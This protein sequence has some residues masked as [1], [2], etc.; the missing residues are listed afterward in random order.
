MSLI[1]RRPQRSP[2]RLP[3]QSPL[4]RRL[5]SP[6]PV[7]M[8]PQLQTPAR[9]TVIPTVRLAMVVAAR[10]LCR[11]VQ[12]L[13]HRALTASASSVLAVGQGLLTVVSSLEIIP[14][15]STHH[16]LVKTTQASLK[17]ALVPVLAVFLAPRRQ[18]YLLQRFC[19]LLPPRNVSDSH[20]GVPMPV[21]VLRQLRP[22]EM[23][24]IQAKQLVVS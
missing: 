10:I 3:P 8:S 4:L 2:P 18:R 1:R 22:L 12:I 17:V 21:S 9:T 19:P 13:L 14:P 20:L 15:R 16:A 11:H 7:P 5:L 6:P 23:R 24:A